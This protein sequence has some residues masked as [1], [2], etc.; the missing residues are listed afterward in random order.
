MRKYW[1]MKSEPSC[2]SIDDLAAA[3]NQTTH[4]DGIRNFQSRNFMRDDMRPGDG[5][6]FYHSNCTT[7]AIVGVAEVISA[8][9]PDF[10]AF[11]P[12]SEHPDLTSTPEHPKWYMVDLQLRETF[13]RAI[14]LDEL[15]RCQ[16]L[17]QMIVLRKGNRLSVSPVLQHEWETI[18]T[19]KEQ[20]YQN[21]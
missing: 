14:T 11:D 3:P 16:D 21:R 7:P 2:F 9:Y 5:V 18:M 1:L 4:W 19:L 10:T 20:A 12:A 13:K 6:L 17:R 15:R 8:A